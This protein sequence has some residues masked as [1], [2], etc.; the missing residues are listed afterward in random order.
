MT[1]LYIHFDNIKPRSIHHH[2]LLT[3]QKKGWGKEFHLVNYHE[4][5]KPKCFLYRLVSKT[6][7]W[8]EPM[9]YLHGDNNMF[10]TNSS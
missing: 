7:Y 2:L 5:H 3:R 9:T 4:M 1:L 8:K 6:L 10:K